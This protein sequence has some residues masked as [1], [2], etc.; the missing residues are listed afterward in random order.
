MVQQLFDMGIRA[1][2]RDRAA[3]QG[4]ELF[5]LERVFSDCVERIELC[6]RHFRRAL[7]IGAPDRHWSAR[8]HPL[9]DEVESA[10]PGPL[11]AQSSNGMTLIEDTWLPPGHAFDLIVAIG[12]LDTVNNLPLAFQLLRHSMAADG[13][14]IGAF[15]GGDT[16]VQLR[17]AMRAADALLEM[18]A[19]HVHPR[20]EAAAVA[21]LLEQAGLVRP[22][23]D[24]DRVNVSYRSLARLVRDL[25][26]M[27]AGNLLTARP[28]FIGKAGLSAASD[29]FERAG[30]G[31]R[32]IETFEII[33]F[34]AWTAAQ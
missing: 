13:L 1:M 10:D 17:K 23:V 6:R 26:G 15:S 22:V 19:P 11:F 30:D 9:A 8:L 25:R 3:R 34:A 7:L 18:A 33:H 20:I 4:P 16:L 24:I 2:R 12:T 5:L 31:D 32:T 21:P 14:L 29:A 28:R 27:A